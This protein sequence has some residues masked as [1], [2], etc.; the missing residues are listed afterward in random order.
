MATNTI[1]RAIEWISADDWT[2]KRGVSI[3][4]REG[5][6][7]RGDVTMQAWEWITIDGRRR[8]LSATR[9]CH[10]TQNR[11]AKF[12]VMD[13]VISMMLDELDSQRE[14]VLGNAA[15]IIGVDEHGR[16]VRGAGNIWPDGSPAEE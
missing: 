9:T 11:L 10:E 13:A 12:D 2:H 6:D 4:T 1:S 16:R 5:D 3:E 15:K 7:S 8:R 14:Q